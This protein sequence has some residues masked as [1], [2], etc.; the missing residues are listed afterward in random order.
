MTKLRLKKTR[1]GTA[2]GKGNRLRCSFLILL[3]NLLVLLCR[4]EK[5]GHQRRRMRDRE[6]DD[7]KADRRR[8]KEESE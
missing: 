3:V 4:H 2:G 7:D 1:N 5:V 6:E 8:E